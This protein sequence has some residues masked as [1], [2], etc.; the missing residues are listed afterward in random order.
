MKAEVTNCERKSD[1][2]KASIILLLEVRLVSMSEEM[3]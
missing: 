2:L 1:K 3:E